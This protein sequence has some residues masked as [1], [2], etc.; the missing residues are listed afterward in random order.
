MRIGSYDEDEVRVLVEEYEEL[1]Y[2][3][4][5]FVRVRLMDL[6]RAIKKLDPPLRQAIVLHGQLGLPQRET[7]RLVGCSQST[8]H[9]RFTNGLDQLLKTLNG[10]R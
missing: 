1:K 8:L 7:A 10:G 3:S 4:R 2:S 5:A 6:D 9:R